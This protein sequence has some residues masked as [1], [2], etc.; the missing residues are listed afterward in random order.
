MVKRVLIV[1]DEQ[2][3]ASLIAGVLD[4]EGYEPRL[5]IGDGGKPA[6]TPMSRLL[7][8]YRGTAQC[9]P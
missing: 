7:P 3:V 9:S 4:L 8:G 6:A 5:A 2:D 1:E